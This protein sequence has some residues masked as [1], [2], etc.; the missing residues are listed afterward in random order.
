[1]KYHACL[2][3]KPSPECCVVLGWEDPLLLVTGQ[4]GGCNLALGIWPVHS[5]LQHNG[6]NCRGYPV[7]GDLGELQTDLELGSTRDIPLYLTHSH[8]LQ[9]SQY[10]SSAPIILSYLASQLLSSVST[11]YA[12]LNIVNLTHLQ[13]YRKRKTCDDLWTPDWVS[14]PCLN[15]RNCII[16]YTFSMKSIYSQFYMFFIPCETVSWLDVHSRKDSKYPKAIKI[17]KG[18]SSGKFYLRIYIQT[19]F[20]IYNMYQKYLQI[21][22]YWF[23]TIIGVCRRK[24]FNL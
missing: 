7:Q 9:G 24:K 20:T 16:Q 21:A 2:A 23:P 22:P 8:P 5:K 15:K 6:R 10:L 14:Y 12:T 3:S 13:K 1:M 19:V 11:I 4:H 17:P 18:H